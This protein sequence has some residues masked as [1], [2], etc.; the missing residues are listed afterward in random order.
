MAGRCDAGRRFR[1]KGKAVYFWGY[2]VGQGGRL[3]DPGFV[4]Q[5][6]DTRAVAPGERLDFWQAQHETLSFNVPDPAIAREYEASLFW[7]PSS[8]GVIFGHATSPDTDMN[9]S[10]Y[11]PDQVLLTETVSGAAR[12]F[13][14]HEEAAEITPGDGLVMFDCKAGARVCTGG[15]LYSHLYLAVPRQMVLEW[16]GGDPFGASPVRALPGGGLFG[17]L[18]AHLHRLSQEG[19]SLDAAE[20]AT[21][22]DVAA[23]FA[24]GGIEKLRARPVEEDNPQSTRALFASAKYFIETRH[25]DAGLTAAA[26]ADHLGCS[27][28]HLYRVFA[29]HDLTV[30]AFLRETRLQKARAVLEN[31]HH[32]SVAQVAAD[33]GY[34]DVTSFSR[35]FRERFGMPPGACRAEAGN[36]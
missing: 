28:A 19:S 25:G 36:S 34:G 29:A 20:A 7:C 23:A 17:F 31:I 26:I 6:A 30:G 14:G 18:R 22:L 1:Y 33:A 11:G 5:R 13:R 2:F 3:S 21:A 8:E 27:R 16:F 15:G 9:F 24:R 35:A 10:T 4:F 32:R 12:I